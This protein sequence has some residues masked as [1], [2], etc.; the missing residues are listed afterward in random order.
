METGVVRQQP[1]VGMQALDIEGRRTE[2]AFD[3]GQVGLTLF[4][5]YCNLVAFLRHTICPPDGRREPTR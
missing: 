5:G 3:H 1:M 2:H 4:V